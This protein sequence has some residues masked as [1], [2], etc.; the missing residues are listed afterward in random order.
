VFDGGQVQWGWIKHDE[1]GKRAQDIAV[2]LGD[3]K[4]LVPAA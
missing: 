2:L 4:L 3:I 1:I